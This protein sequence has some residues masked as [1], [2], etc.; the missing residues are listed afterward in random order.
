M[1]KRRK[2]PLDNGSGTTMK[3]S[4]ITLGELDRAMEAYYKAQKEAP[5]REAR[6]VFEALKSFEK[7]RCLGPHRKAGVLAQLHPLDPVGKKKR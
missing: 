7:D 2:S 6:W 1:P 3:V 5:Q 4:S